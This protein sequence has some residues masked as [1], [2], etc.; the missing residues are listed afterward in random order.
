V[1]LGGRD[2]FVGGSWRE[3]EEVGGYHR[4]QGTGEGVQLN[5]TNAILFITLLY[6]FQ[7]NN[8]KELTS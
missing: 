6:A 1:R 3:W 7:L 5:N 8:K 2:G 4:P